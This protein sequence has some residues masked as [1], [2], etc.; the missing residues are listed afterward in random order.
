MISNRTLM[1]SFAVCIAVVFSGCSSTTNIEGVAENAASSS[2]QAAPL[3]I[4]TVPDAFFAAGIECRSPSV[5]EYRV[6]DKPYRQLVCIGD[7]GSGGGDWGVNVMVMGSSDVL[8]SALNEY[9][10]GRETTSSGGFPLLEGVAM[11]ANW[12][13]YI[14]AH[15]GT[16]LTKSP[17]PG[18][19]AEALGGQPVATTE[20]ACAIAKERAA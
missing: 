16:D 3:D 7:P 11:G 18:A 5:R 4:E 6:W 12:I 13:A 2:V 14:E 8:Y 1:V 10:G 9:C 15:S 19:L 17:T 20:E